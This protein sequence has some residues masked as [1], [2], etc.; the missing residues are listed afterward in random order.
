MRRGLNL[1]E[2]PWPAL[3]GRRRTLEEELHLVLRDWRAWDLHQ[4]TDLIRFRYGVSPKANAES[5]AIVRRGR[6]I[7]KARTPLLEAIHGRREPEVEQQIRADLLDFAVIWADLRVR[8]AKTDQADEVPQEALREALR[9]LD[10]AAD[11]LGPSPA[12]DRDRRH[13]ARTLG[14]TRSPRCHSTRPRTAWE[15]YDLGKSYLRSGKLERAAEQFRLAL[16][17]RPQ[18]FWP[19]FYQGL[20]A[21]RHGRFNEAVQA[22]SICQALAPETAEC[23]YNL[24][25]AHEALGQDDQALRDYRRALQV[26]HRLLQAALNRGILLSRHGRHAEATAALEEALAITNPSDQETLGA[27]HYNLALIQLALDRRSNALVHLQAAKDAGH[28][29]ARAPQAPHPPG[30]VVESD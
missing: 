28:Q 11:Q 2:T 30:S 18:D 6:E 23:S 14:M 10:E 21:Y 29:E 5:R 20:C 4:L 22:F 16:E 9:I 12:L 15:H 13:Y 19:N 27:V 7:W 26:D 1:T 25:L 8:L 17:L 24:A 3:T